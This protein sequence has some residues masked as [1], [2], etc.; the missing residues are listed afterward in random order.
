[1]GNKTTEDTQCKQVQASMKGFAK[2]VLL[3]IFQRIHGIA[4]TWFCITN[5][6]PNHEFM[7]CVVSLG[8]DPT[9]P[10]ILRV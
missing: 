2:G 9:I 1:M 4:I 3:L 7:N 8:D 6:I 10:E 5:K